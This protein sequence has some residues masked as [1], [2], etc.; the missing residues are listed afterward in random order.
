MPSLWPLCT[1]PSTWLNANAVPYLQTNTYV[2]EKVDTL[3][4]TICKLTK[5]HTNVT[6]ALN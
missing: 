6:P 3:L 5:M 1:C 4:H 2:F